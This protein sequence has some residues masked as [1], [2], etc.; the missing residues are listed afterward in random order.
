METPGVERIGTVV[1]GGG[2]A[3]L[4]VGYHLKRHALPF[5]IVDANHRVGDAWRNRWDSL[6]L[7]TPAWLDGLDGMPFPAP[8]HSFPTKDEMA[9]YLERY[10]ERFELPVMNGLRVGSLRRDDGRFVIDAGDRRFE[11]DNVVVAMSSWQVPAIPSFASD[12]DPRITQLHSAAY[13]GPR[14]LRPGPVLV[15]GAGNSGAEIALDVVNGHRT[16]LAGPS[17]G[18]IPF[19]VDGLVGRV[20]VR[21]VLRVLFHRVFT[22]RTPIGRKV[23]R[24]MLSKG[25]P[26]VRTKPKDL[27]AAGIERTG[28]VVGARDGLPVLEGGEV[29]DVANVIWSTGFSPGFSWIELPV[30]DDGYPRQRG[31]I[32]ADEPGLYFVGLKFLYAASSA[33]LPGVGRDASRVADHLAARVELQ[34][35]VP[36]AARRGAGE[37]IERRSAELR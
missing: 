22:V 1:I 35:P 34:P 7:F 16:I 9:D 19:R 20:G 25:E 4:S 29:V 23:R 33:T 14:Q 21:I 30:V 10:A 24:M 36:A 12:L 6:R 26:L 28:R 17:T 15:A 32:V 3:G 11:A 37:D 13:R 27:A 18:H 5:V 31:G 8:R 2:Q